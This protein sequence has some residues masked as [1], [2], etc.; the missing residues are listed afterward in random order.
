MTDDNQ[1]FPENSSG[2]PSAVDQK[3]MLANLDED[4]GESLEGID[5]TDEISEQGAALQS[6]LDHNLPAAPGPDEDTE[7][8]PKSQVQEAFQQVLKAEEE[9]PQSLVARLYKKRDK[10]SDLMAEKEKLQLSHLLCDSPAPYYEC[11]REESSKIFQLWVRIKN[12][13]IQ[14]QAACP[15]GEESA[16][17]QEASADQGAEGAAAN[18]SMN[19]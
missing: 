11:W 13:A 3:D 8:R 18:Q 17:G 1:E 5:S 6:D 9:E 2:S 12:R 14:E 7:E 4:A 16:D 15:R 10:V 19:E